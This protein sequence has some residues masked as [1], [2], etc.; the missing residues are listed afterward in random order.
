MAL[1]NIPNKKDKFEKVAFVKE[2]TSHQ[3]NVMIKNL[4]ENFQDLANRCEENGY[5]QV[6]EAIDAILDGKSFKS[7]I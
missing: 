5:E 3:K 2:M 6:A 7:I 4:W 1:I